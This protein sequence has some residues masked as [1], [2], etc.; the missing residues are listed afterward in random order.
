MLDS[1]E[2]KIDASFSFRCEEALGALYLLERPEFFMQDQDDP[3]A[4]HWKGKQLLRDMYGDDAVEA[5]L[6]LFIQEQSS[7]N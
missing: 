3:R 1:K 5:A 7:T 6:E 2:K 4:K